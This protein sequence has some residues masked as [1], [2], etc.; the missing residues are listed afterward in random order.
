MDKKVWIGVRN[1]IVP[2]IVLWALIGL[3]MTLIGCTTTQ[4]VDEAVDWDGIA[5]QIKV[6]CKEDGKAC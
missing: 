1:A 3:A 5:E 6:S 2:S 4:P